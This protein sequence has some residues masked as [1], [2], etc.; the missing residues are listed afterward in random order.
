MTFLCLAVNKNMFFD[1]ILKEAVFQFCGEI[2]MN[3]GA[4]CSLCHTIWLPNGQILN[5]NRFVFKSYNINIVYLLY[6]VAHSVSFLLKIL[7]VYFAVS[8][9]NFCFMALKPI[10]SHLI[11]YLSSFSLFFFLFTVSRWSPFSI[12]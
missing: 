6:S 7:F 1:A 3:A 5:P 2:P 9:L 4:C 12:W 8:S 11:Q 10:H